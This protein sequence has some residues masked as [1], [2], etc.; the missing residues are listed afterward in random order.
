MKRKPY[1]IEGREEGKGKPWKDSFTTLA[2]AQAHIKDR[3]SGPDY[4]DG[5]SGYHT[6]YATFRLIGFTLQDIGSRRWSDGC[7]EWDWL[8]FDSP[9]PADSPSDSD[10]V[11]IANWKARAEAIKRAEAADAVDVPF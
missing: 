8:D 7:F 11:D 3:W 10:A 2:E 1:K 4:I 6:D 9:S 5:P